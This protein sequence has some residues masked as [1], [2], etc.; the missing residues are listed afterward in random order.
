MCVLN[1]N[2]VSKPC[3]TNGVNYASRNWE[4]LISEEGIAKLRKNAACMICQEKVPQIL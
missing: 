2:K 4:S 1:K 3:M